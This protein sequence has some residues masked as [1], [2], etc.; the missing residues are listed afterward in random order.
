MERGQVHL[1]SW[2]LGKS[3][4]ARGCLGSRPMGSSSRRL[5]LRRRI[6]ALDITFELRLNAF[7]N[8][9]CGD[10]FSLP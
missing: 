3:A 2:T 8:A 7:D 5:R 6:L 10:G 9:T 4:S 1:G